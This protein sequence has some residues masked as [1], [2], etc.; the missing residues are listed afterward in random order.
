MA[1][2]AKIENI[3][4]NP[5][6]VD[7]PLIE[8][9]SAELETLRGKKRKFSHFP[10]A[11]M[12]MLKHVEGNQ[13]CI[14]CGAHDPQ[15]ATISYGALLCL[16]C[17]GHHRSLG[18]QVSC[19]R[20]ISMDEWSVLEVVAML[21]GGNSQL[22][23]FFAR[24]ALTVEACSQSTNTGNPKVIHKDN[25]TR[26]RYKTK[27]AEFYRQQMELHVCKVVEA[28]PYRGREISRRSR[29]PNVDRRNSE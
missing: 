24:H 13:Q 9:A 21:E 11:C 4:D 14:D 27:A 22:A 16:Q 15:W 3:H 6:E 2:A 17:S 29:R 7:I 12:A 20:S 26:L 28:G 1:P 25:V 18:V 8:M 10:A 19:V 23:T 5:A